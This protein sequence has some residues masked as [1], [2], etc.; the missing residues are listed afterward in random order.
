M[1]ILDDTYDVK[2]I[3]EKKDKQILEIIFFILPHH[4]PHK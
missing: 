4:I 3:S 1:N 2:H